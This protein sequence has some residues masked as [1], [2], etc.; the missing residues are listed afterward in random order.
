MT[1]MQALLFSDIR[2]LEQVEIERPTP[3]RAGD[4]LL[5]VNA[6]GVCG[7]DLHGY[8]GQ[9]GRR[10]PPLIM[11]HELTATVVE[12]K[13]GGGDAPAPG[14]RV[15]VYPLD[16]SGPAR[17]L[18]GMDEPGAFAEYVVWPA[19]NLYALPDGVSA[20]A[21]SLAEPLAV[22]IHAVGRARVAPGDSA[23][24]AGAGPI[25]LLVIAV[26]RSMGVGPILVSDLSE[27]RLDVALAL[28]ATHALHARRVDLGEAV[29]AATGGRGVDL[30]FE[31]VGITPTVQQ[32]L[33]A[34]RD[35]GTVV[36]IGNNQRTVEVDM[37][38]VV[39]R[40]LSVLGTYGMGRVDFERALSTLADGRIDSARL[41]NRRATLDEGPA[42]FETLLASPEILKCIFTFD[43]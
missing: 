39:T 20:E 16:F 3:Q 18:I 10:T 19:K 36:W 1:T 28:G 11:G 25:G 35:G 29:H 31:A 7:S 32:S 41:I 40:E 30:S 42:L 15:A 37:Q 5:K 27:E 34:V 6:A 17:R 8:T 33:T 26:L 13:G 43:D 23:F 2:T 12:S 9:S 21:G 24:V 38:S 14:T 4:V 22:A